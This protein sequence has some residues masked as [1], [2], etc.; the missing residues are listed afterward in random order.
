M[1]TRSTPRR[2]GRPRGPVIDPAVRRGQLLDAA[3]RAIRQHGPDASMEDLAA[4]AGITRPILYQ[5]FGDRAGIGRALVQEFVDEI[6]ARV[7]AALDTGATTEESVQ[8]VIAA[9]VE[10][11]DADPD[12]YRFVIRESVRSATATAGRD[13]SIA[14]RLLGFED[15]GA[16]LTV[17]LA[18]ELTRAGRDP[19]LAEPLAY[20]GMGAVLFACE[21]WLSHDKAMPAGQLAGLLSH[22]VW[23]GIV[24]HG[25]GE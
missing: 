21:W 5:H 15:I 12:V 22:Q 4:E 25:P 13:E 18:S 19:D 6:T 8:L 20:A 17:A 24:H 23:A 10:F 7:A 2:V 14:S 11:V 16:T 9:F 3:A 1:V